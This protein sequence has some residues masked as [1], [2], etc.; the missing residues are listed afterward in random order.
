[1]QE[2][3]M[4]MHEARR[5]D[6]LMRA[7]AR[8]KIHHEHL[9]DGR[10]RIREVFTGASDREVYEKMDARAEQLKAAGGRNFR[11]TRLG[12]NSACPCGS[13]R[14]FKKCCMGAAT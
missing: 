14:K 12:R 7:E 1:M 6:E 9:V 5:L 13:G 10:V 11:R 3:T 2:C 4:E 8:P